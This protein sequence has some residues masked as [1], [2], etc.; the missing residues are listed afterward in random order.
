MHSFSLWIPF[1]N[2]APLQTTESAI[3]Q[4]SKMFLQ[5]WQQSNGRGKLPLLRECLVR[6][7]DPGDAQFLRQVEGATQ[8]RRERY[9]WCLV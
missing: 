6:V 7:V 4:A 3:R 8:G 2:P 9:D 5:N 1:S